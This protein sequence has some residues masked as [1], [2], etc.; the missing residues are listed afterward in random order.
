MCSYAATLILKA[1][2]RSKYSCS[3]GNQSVSSAQTSL[4]LGGEERLFCR[5]PSAN[6]S[7]RW[8]Y[9]KPSSGLGISRGG[10]PSF[11][12][13]HDWQ[14]G[15]WK[16]KQCPSS[17][18]H[19][20]LSVWWPNIRRWLGAC[21]CLDPPSRTAKR[22]DLSSFVL[23]HSSLFCP[24]LLSNKLSCVARLASWPRGNGFPRSPG[25]ATL[26]HYRHATASFWSYVG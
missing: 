8:G 1:V 17:H 22:S 16:Q 7:M 10:P 20:C 6:S 24:P 3:T 23:L 18:P 21:Q 2:F 15:P 4:S 11:T 9:G 13:R 14:H 5:Q 12:A 25:T 26:Y 19:V